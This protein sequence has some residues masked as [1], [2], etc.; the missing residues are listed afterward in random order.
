MKTISLAGSKAH[1]KVRFALVLPR[2][3]FAKCACIVSKGSQSRD[4][5]LLGI[6]M[7]HH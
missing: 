3:A 1:E 7:A 6:Q 4:Q 5:K 2:N